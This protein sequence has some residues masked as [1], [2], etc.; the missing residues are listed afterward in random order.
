MG[1]L[2]SKFNINRKM[3]PLFIFTTIIIGI[4]VLAKFIE[5]KPTTIIKHTKQI[6]KTA[7]TPSIDSKLR[8]TVNKTNILVNCVIN[9][10]NT[11]CESYLEYWP[12]KDPSNK[13]QTDSIIINPSSSPTIIQQV[14]T[15]YDKHTNYECKLILTNQNGTVESKPYKF[16]TVYIYKLTLGSQFTID[17]TEAI[18]DYFESSLLSHFNLY[19]QSPGNKT[20]YRVRIL[21]RNNNTIT[22]K[23]TNKRIKHGFYSLYIAYK[24]IQ[25]KVTPLILL[26]VPQVDIVFIEDDKCLIEGRYF[27]TLQPKIILLNK[28]NNKIGR[29][30]IMQYFN[31][32]VTNKSKII[33]KLPKKAKLL[34]SKIKLIT[35]VGYTT[36]RIDK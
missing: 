13:L 7:Q 20:K 3:K 33:C 17:K 36:F 10:Y 2:F 31:D 16:C 32:P 27:S 29:A 15:E 18:K 5:K 28:T 34:L 24:R 1:I 26:C 35:R 22:C 25:T 4:I 9:N 19:L 8:V 12:F 14:I 30:R 21:N 23:L 11:E 6:Y